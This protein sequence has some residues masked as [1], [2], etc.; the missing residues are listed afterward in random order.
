MI[1]TLSPQPLPVYPTRQ[2][3]RT[4]PSVACVLRTSSKTRIMPKK[5]TSP[6][7]IT[8]GGFLSAGGKS[9][10]YYHDLSYS[11][12]HPACANSWGTYRMFMVD[13]HYQ[14]QQK[15]SQFF[16]AQ[17]ITQEWAEPKD[18]EHRL[19]AASSEVKDSHGHLLVTGYPL[20]RP[21]GQWSLMLINKDHDYSSS[22]DRIS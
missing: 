4:S 3:R 22:Q 7:M 13:E 19:Y 20:Q 5:G 6:A 21:D 16:A 11:P 12:P 2:I 9:T 10:H 1:F 17:L 18:A 15:T 14:I 8:I